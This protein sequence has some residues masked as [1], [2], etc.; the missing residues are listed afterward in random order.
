MRANSVVLGSVAAENR[1]L[2]VVGL[3]IGLILLVALT[4]SA[5]PMAAAATPS[6]PDVPATDRYF[7][8]ISD[9][10]SRGIVGG[11][12]NGN[13]G[14][15]DPVTRQQ[16][17]KMI[18]LTGG[19]SVSEADVCSFTDV[20]KGGFTDPLFP[21]NYIA[22]CAAKGITAGKTPTTFDP[23]G[24]LTR[25]QA[26][27]MVVRAA[28]NL[29]PGLLVDPPAGFTG[30][31]SGNAV[32]SSNAAIAENGGLLAG[33]DLAALDPYGTM[34]RGEVAQVLHHLLMKLNDSQAAGLFWTWYAGVPNT[35][36]TDVSAAA[37][38]FN[39]KLY[40]FAKGMDNKKLS[41][42]QFD[43]ATWSAFTV[44][45]TSGTTD[46]A[47]A[48]TVFAGKLYVFAKG[49]GDKKLYVST[50]DGTTWSGFTL[51]P[52]SVTTDVAPAATVLNGKL[53]L[54]AKGVDDKQLYMS[55]FDGTAWGGFTLVP[56]GVT[57]DAA[58]AAAV[59]NG[60][61]YLFAT[62]VEDTKLYVSGF[63][64]TNWSGFSLVPVSSTT[65][66]GPAAAVF[67]GKLYLFGKGIGD[68]QIYVSAF[69]GTTWSAFSRV[70]NGSTDV[71]PGVGVLNDQLYLFTKGIGDKKLY[72]SAGTP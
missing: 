1:K 7:A 23:S 70:A 27:S 43:G 36:T 37:A 39:G 53:Y 21:D 42:C 34:S 63:D 8:A 61:L 44:I 25:Y 60:R 50:F 35:V 65:D 18:V 46:A 55:T 54:F 57:T 56:S 19:Y 9:L 41:V 64:G 48:A 68:K 67:N 2:L 16:F 69:D 31:W 4:V 30:T 3:C 66:T 49:V 72:F 15:G 29:K 22:V 38:G 28:N 13:F 11:L 33:L 47:P 24:K 26:V 59:F 17:A 58:P 10:A 32:H 6:F 45:P 14:P 5:A 51:I 20:Q 62:R 52:A 40:L 71:A 12:A